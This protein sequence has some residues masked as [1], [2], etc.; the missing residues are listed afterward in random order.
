M[1]WWT[2][3][4]AVPTS[5]SSAAEE[6]FKQHRLIAEQ[7]GQPGVQ[8]RLAILCRVMGR[9][10]QHSAVD[11][12]TLREGW[13]QNL[14]LRPE[15]HS[16]LDKGLLL[17]PPVTLSPSACPLKPSREI[18][19]W[20]RMFA[21]LGMKSLRVDDSLG[22]GIPRSSWAKS[23]AMQKSLLRGSSPE[24]RSSREVSESLR[25]RVYL[26]RFSM[27]VEDEMRESVSRHAVQLMFNLLCL[28]WLQKRGPTG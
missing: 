21:T 11:G 28:Y 18:G 12:G 24:G 3:L 9:L 16:A 1:W 22:E 14:W 27:P 20:S 25:R 15:A 7:G 17:R 13:L 19:L 23:V 4:P 2:T 26:V 6:V 8:G 10:V 5:A